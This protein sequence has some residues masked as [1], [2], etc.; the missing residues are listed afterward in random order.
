MLGDCPIDVLAHD[1]DV[2]L[3]PE[4][5]VGLVRVEH[6]RLMLLGVIG[7]PI[8]SRRDG[9]RG[10][11]RVS[12]VS[13]EPASLQKH[14]EQSA[15]V[16][17]AEFREDWVRYLRETVLGE[18]WARPVLC[19]RDRSLVSVA[20]LTALN[21]PTDLKAQMRA[22]LASG[23]SARTLY[24]VVF[25]AGGYAGYGLALEA[26]SALKTV[27]QEAG[28]AG[29]PADAEPVESDAAG[30]DLETR[31]AAVLEALLPRRETYLPPPAHYDFAPDWKKWT[32]TSCFGGCW[33]RPGLTLVERSR[34]TMAVVCV[35]GQEIPLRSHIGV[36]CNLG[37]SREEIGEQIMHLAV[38]RGYSGA[39]NAMQIAEEVFAE[40]DGREPIPLAPAKPVGP[41]RVSG[42]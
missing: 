13:N 23:I 28:I 24:E 2:R 5:P 12:G 8:M 22:A 32:A 18:I 36:A 17:P 35:L 21:C 37:I 26:L 42:G 3:L 41:C 29:S 31:M 7:S 30:G 40:A 6:V 25:H 19:T 38:Y 1:S 14:L 9:F 15:E 39:V 34:V 27:M 4:E 16:V 33:A 10:A 20:A 11:E